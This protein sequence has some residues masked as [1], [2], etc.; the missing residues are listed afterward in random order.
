[1]YTSLKSCLIPKL[2]LKKLWDV[3]TCTRK[4]LDRSSLAYEGKFSL[5][6]KDCINS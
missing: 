4:G 5:K 3:R 2:L 6:N 1:M